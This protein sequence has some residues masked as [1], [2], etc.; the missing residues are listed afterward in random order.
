MS[1]FFV[2]PAQIEAVSDLG[3]LKLSA[4]RQAALAPQFAGLVAAANQLSATIARDHGHPTPVAPIV[5][6]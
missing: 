5:R 4:E 3:N 1:T 6:F 2:I